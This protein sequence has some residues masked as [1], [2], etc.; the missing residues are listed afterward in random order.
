MN[1]FSKFIT[2]VAGLGILS[3]LVTAASTEMFTLQINSSGMLVKPS[4]STFVAANG[5][6]VQSQLMAASN[7]LYQAIGTGGG[8]SSLTFDPETLTLT[9]INNGGSSS[10][11]FD[12]ETLTLTVIN[13]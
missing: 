6:V 12:P 10:L 11:T 3:L 13:K 8:S 1:R 7:S 2:T 5:L 9:A 4:L